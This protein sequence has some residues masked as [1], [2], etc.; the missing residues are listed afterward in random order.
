MKQDKIKFMKKTIVFFLILVLLVLTINLL[1]RQSILSRTILERTDKQFEEYKKEIKIL[2]IGDSHTKDNI[3][4]LMINNSFNFASSGENYMET[5]YKLKTILKDENLKLEVIILPIDLH[6]FSSFRTNRFRNEWYWK[7]YV[8]YKEVAVFNDD[9]FFLIKRS[10]LSVCPVIGSGTRILMPLLRESEIIK[11]H[12][13]SEGNFSKIENRQEKA[14]QR[15][16]YLL[17][18]QEVLDKILLL[19][20]KKSLELVKENKLKVVLVKFPITREHHNASNKYV[21]NK[22]IFYSKIDK[23]I[24]TV[25]YEPIYILDYQNIYFDKNYLFSND[26]HL[27]PRGIE[28]FSKKIDQDLKTVLS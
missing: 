15:V 14:Q 5:Y 25:N 28:I 9:N 23:I 13:K 19:Y 17:K 26:D 27:N 6:S 11:G 22:T 20:F 21:P 16:D 8:N 1:F 12:I 10:I 4:P 18:N 7:K 24:K 3:N 2:F